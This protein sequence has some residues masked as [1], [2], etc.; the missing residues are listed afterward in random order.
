MSKL[1]DLTGQ[2]FGYLTVIERDTSK[3][4]GTYWNCQCDCGNIKS[5]K[6]SHLKD[7]LTISCGCYK[8][9]KATKDITNQKFGKL[10]AL[11]PTNKRAHNRGIIWHCSCECGNEID[12]RIDSLTTGHSQSCG[13]SNTSKGEQNIIKILNDNNITYIKEKVFKDFIYEDTGGY[14]R[15]DFYLPDYNRLIEFDGSQHFQDVFWG[16]EKVLTLE[17]RKQKDNIKDNYAKEHNIDLV[18]IPYWE[19]EN[20]TLNMILGNKY[21][22]EFWRYDNG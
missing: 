20:I 9:K 17:E 21:L 15:F 4:N 6:G 22:V 1:I 11:Y 14:P 13:C 19:L 5:I 3:K 2:H 12:I 16:R 7:G 18:R 10:I 8:I